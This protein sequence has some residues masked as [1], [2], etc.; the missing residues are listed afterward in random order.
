MRL[1]C[2]VLFRFHCL[3]SRHLNIHEN[4]LVMHVACTIQW[5]EKR[6]RYQ[7]F[8]FTLRLGNFISRSPRRRREIPAWLSWIFKDKNGFSLITNRKASMLDCKSTL[9]LSPHVWDS[10][11]VVAW[12]GM[13]FISSRT[14]KL[15]ATHKDES[16]TATINPSGMTSS[17][18]RSPRLLWIF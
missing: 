1:A 13:T 12:H 10:F 5:K 6:Q 17:I 18:Q 15:T 2:F 11:K 8:L 14:A 4:C 3:R 7:R 9:I 16:S